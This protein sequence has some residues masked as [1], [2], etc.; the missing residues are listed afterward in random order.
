MQASA[1]RLAILTVDEIQELYGL[2]QFTYE[3]RIRYFSLTLLETKELEWFRT[4]KSKII[5]VLQ[6]AYFKAKR[7]FFTF[8][9][10]EAQ[11]DVQYIRQ[12]IFPEEEALQDITIS[13]PN[14]LFQQKRILELFNY[15]SCTQE[16][17][18]KIQEKAV[19]TAAI[20]AKPIFIFK[21]LI[22]YLQN[23]K[24]VLPAYSSMQ[25]IVGKALVLEKTRLEAEVTQ[26]ISEAISKPLTDL[27]YSR[28]TLY[29]LT[30]IKK[31]AKDFSY[32]EIQQEVHRRQT[33][34][35]L[36]YFTLNFL[37]LLKISNENIK[38]Y[39]SLIQYYSIYKLRRMNA[40][41]VYV[42]LLCF[43]F[44]RF[45]KV[46]D[47]LVNS[48]IYYVDKYIGVAKEA[49][50]T[51][52]SSL[53][54]E[55]NEN[56]EKAGE[57]LNLFI[58]DSILDITPFGEVKNMAFGILEKEK[59][60]L[61]S[62]YISNVKFDEVEYEWKHCEKLAPT[63]KRNL[64]PIFLAMELRS[65]RKD[66][67]LIAAVTFLKDT[68]RNK[69]NLTQMRNYI[70]PQRIISQ[71][72]RRYFYDKKRELNVDR[73][74]FL[75]YRLLK[76][77]L[78]A[79]DIFV[80]DS[81]HFKRFEE[82]LIDSERWKN[83]EQIIE[84]LGLP[85]LRQPI[86]ETLASLEQELESKIIDVNTRIAQ[87]QNRHIKITI[88]G[89]DRRW[90]LPYQRIP[91]IENH[92]F[93]N[94]LPPIEINDL[95]AFVNE[96]SGFMASF[97]H[98][99]ERYVKNDADNQTIVACVIA[100]GENMGIRKMSEISDIGY[101]TLVT[102]TGNFIRLETLKNA[103]D[104]V[105]NATAQLPLFRYYNLQEDII[106]SS[107]D[108]QKFETQIDTIR[109]RY[110]PKY[111]GLN[112][113]LSSYTHVANYV[114][115][116]AQII[117]SNEHESHYVFDVL[118]N[119]TSDI[120]PDRV[121]V[122][123]YGR[124]NVNAAILHL[125]GYLFA[126]RYSELNQDSKVIYSFKSP[127]AYKDCLIKPVRK[128][129]T[130]LIKEEWD[131]IQRIMVSLALKETTQSVIVKKLSSTK[132]ASKTKRALWEY[133][134][135]ISSLYALDYIDNLS[136]RQNVQGA[137][138]R[139]ESYHKLKRAVFHDNFGRFRVNTELEQEIW[140][141]CTRL[142]ANCIIFYNAYILSHLLEYKE[143]MGQHEETEIIKRIS[144]IAWRHVN[145]YGRF[146]FRKKGTTDVEKIVDALGRI[147]WGTLNL[148]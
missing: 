75:I 127:I 62:K 124:N 60:P 54:I 58:N 8:S 16:M 119:N 73:Y 92:P 120:Q 69:K 132:R 29:E 147:Y 15:Q 48:F 113:G 47:N 41:I 133:D 19:K 49:S 105:S 40:Q 95:L 56:L 123:M 12:Q 34:T 81:I 99:L 65:P 4:T 135:I 6:L 130:S 91:G 137:L 85:H 45:Q 116:N 136:L 114:P 146:E 26:H 46:N 13:K 111:F 55:S 5:F 109:S 9:F 74:E 100:Q 70:Y 50:Q 110:S 78:E 21:D 3:D 84:S 144:P 33:L 17:K 117:G 140:S 24:I 35:S 44:N 125:F 66:A 30:L 18:E 102:T 129:N 143:K 63:I 71:R 89:N 97:I 82:D 142:I 43:I 121:S 76:N 106:H 90:R 68:L 96:K 42:Y 108:G 11:E 94:E 57:V 61:M 53:K 39:A 51:E 36:Y 79:Y 98:I 20:C 112:K 64:R 7:M 2:P 1:R 145:L 139:G 28:N 83:K 23:Q 10:Q 37:P 93:Y 31:E 138:N 32:Q 59:F 67:P 27:L 148:T 118:F 134:N 38:Y 122:D 101:H 52:V 141:E 87:G 22:S 77:D 131:N 14:K 115:I 72:V 128:I 88:S 103:N 104:K 107:S 80:P 126:P 25:D 86:T